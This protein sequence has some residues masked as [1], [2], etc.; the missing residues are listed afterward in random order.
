MHDFLPV[1]WEFGKSCVSDKLTQ[2]GTLN[3]VSFSLC[4]VILLFLVIR[5]QFGKA[6]KKKAG[7]GISETRDQDPATPPPPLKTPQI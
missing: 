4:Y 2:P 1:C 5:E 7:C 3:V 6:M